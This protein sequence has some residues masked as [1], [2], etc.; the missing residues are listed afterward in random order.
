MRYKGQYEP[1]EL[2]CPVTRQ[3]VLLDDRLRAKLDRREGSAFAEGQSAT[4]LADRVSA[5]GRA[6]AF[7]RCAMIHP[8]HGLVLRPMR[9]RMTT[10]TKLRELQ[11][12]VGSEVAMAM[13][14]FIE[15][16]GR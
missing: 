12:L 11:S 6:L 16:D 1:S 5:V 2:L 13:V 8:G 3:W 14:P 10:S 7:R 15:D 4:H 9:S